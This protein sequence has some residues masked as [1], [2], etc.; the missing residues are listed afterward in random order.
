MEPHR[1]CNTM[2]KLVQ[3]ATATSA[4]ERCSIFDEER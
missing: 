2:N 1:G 3:A 4:E